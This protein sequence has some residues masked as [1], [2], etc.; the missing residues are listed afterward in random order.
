MIRVPQLVAEALRFPKN[1]TP[2]GQCDIYRG[3][4]LQ[5]HNMSK[6]D[7]HAI[8]QLIDEVNGFPK[9][10]PEDL[11]VQNQNKVNKISPRRVS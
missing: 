9:S 2:G 10:L 7:A 3:T 5:T 8:A 6:R 4:T 1:I 11:V